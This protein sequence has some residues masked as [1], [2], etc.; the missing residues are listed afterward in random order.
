LFEQVVNENITSF[1]LTIIAL[2]N[3][4]DMLLSE[5]RT[6]GNEQIMSKIKE[7][8][9]MIQEI[10]KDQGSYWLQAE[11]YWLQ[12]QVSLIELDYERAKRLLTQAQLIAED[13]GLLLLAR[14]ISSEFDALLEEQETWTKRGGEETP[15]A[16][17]VKAAHIDELV[18]RMAKMQEADA[19]ELVK[20][21]P[22]QFLMVAAYGGFNLVSI[23]FQE[24]FKV[25]E[26]L[27]SGFLSAL[28][29]FSDEVF[30]MPLDRIKV[31]DYI[32]LM[33]AE[34]PFLFCYVFKGESYSAMQKMTQFIEALQADAQLW[35]S[36]ETTV[37][38][39]KVDNQAKSVV[40]QIIVEILS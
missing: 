9:D 37:T 17:R 32:M 34:L 38:S 10:A 5:L 12:S 18:G 19:P 1:E 21:D 40:E 24:G 35:K 29:T 6:S 39:G 11:T 27:V 33:R 3:L 15:I 2:L 23:E 31:G 22:V 25:D 30:A 13:K 4:C 26:S 14:R 16:E 36:L 7:Y 28:T 8:S 20:E